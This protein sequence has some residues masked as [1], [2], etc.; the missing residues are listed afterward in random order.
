LN[1]Y[2]EAIKRIPKE[3]L[4]QRARVLTNKSYAHLL[5]RDW[6]NVITIANGVVN[7]CPTT[8]DLSEEFSDIKSMSLI[9]K[10]IALKKM[11]KNKDAVELLE[12]SRDDIKYDYYQ[13]GLLA[14]LG[15]E[16]DAL[17]LLKRAFNAEK[18]AINDIVSVDAK[19]APSLESLRDSPL[20]KELTKEIN[21]KT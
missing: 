5:A 16:K 21:D 14:L 9:N 4:F 11:R 15:K 2:D 10:A 8:P 13:A 3:A 20:Y 7:E 1:R 19:Y 6:E 17:D 18:T 12:K